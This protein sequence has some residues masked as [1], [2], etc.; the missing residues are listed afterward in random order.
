MNHS[1]SVLVFLLGAVL[2]ADVLPAAA[3]AALAEDFRIENT[4][5][6][7][8]QKEPPTESTTVFAG[9]VVYDFMKTPAETVVF[10]QSAA[11]FVVLNLRSRT[12]TELTTDELA[13][14]TDR[15]QQLAA[16]NSDPLVKF[17]AAPKFQEHFNEGTRE[18]SLS[19]ASVNYRLLLAQEAAPATVEAYHE[20]SDWY[21]RLNALLAPG[22]G[23][24]P[25]FARLVVNAALAQRKALPLQVTL[26]VVPSKSDRQAITICSTHRVVRPLA[27]ADLDRVA[28][29]RESVVGFKLVSFDQYRKAELR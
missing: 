2:S 15:L 6:V 27:P 12:R 13:R 10:D 29:T 21:A 18:L 8:G 7:A 5:Y 28:K 4:A 11:R 1:R 20:F 9:N 22:S 25:P 3:P 23:S 14:F 17:L 19:S 26:T 24:R 16:R